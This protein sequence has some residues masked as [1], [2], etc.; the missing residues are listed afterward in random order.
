MKR[1]CRLALSV[2]LMPAGLPAVAQAQNFGSPTILPPLNSSLV[3]SCTLETSKSDCSG[4]SAQIMSLVMEL[5]NDSSKSAVH[6]WPLYIQLRTNHDRG[7]AVGAYARMITS[8]AGWSAGLHSEGI[9][10]GTGTTIGSNIEQSNQSGRGRVIGLNI[11]AKSGYAD[12]DKNNWSDEAINIQSDPRSGWKAGL[13]FNQVSLEKGIVFDTGSSGKTA[14]DV[15]GRFERG[16]DLN[17][18]TLVLGR[19]G[20]IVLDA[21]EVVL[22]FNKEA[23]QIE[24]RAGDALVAK[25]PLGAKLR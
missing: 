8:G 23:R 13:K 20:K 10:S 18:N 12:V 4:C 17:G 2:I 5:K 16:L 24:I 3:Y 9:H 21:E 22:L 11:Q 6:P 14:I 1:W 7:D 25:F 19:G 15:A